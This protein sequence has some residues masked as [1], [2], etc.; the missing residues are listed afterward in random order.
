MCAPSVHRHALKRSRARQLNRSPPPVSSSALAASPTS[1]SRPKVTS[2]AGPSTSVAV[3]V[4]SSSSRK[5]PLTTG[6]SRSTSAATYAYRTARPPGQSTPLHLTSVMESPETGNS[7]NTPTPAPSTTKQIAGRRSTPPSPGS[8][9]HGSTSE[10][11]LPAKDKSG[12]KKR[13]DK[14]KRPPASVA[15][16]LPVT[17][18]DVSPDPVKSIVPNTVEDRDICDPPRHDGQT[19]LDYDEQPMS[20]DIKPEPSTVAQAGFEQ[21]RPG[22]DGI[23]TDQ[24]DPALSMRAG[25]IVN[26]VSFSP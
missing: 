21:M 6:Q 13:R 15:T 9:K 23:E 10:G 17:T 24:D 5:S 12:R 4:A 26:G 7:T 2:D 14:L 19:E 3:P 11:P 8:S 25:L 20:A 16:M 22:E 1:G 18:T